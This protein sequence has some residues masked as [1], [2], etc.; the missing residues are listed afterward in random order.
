MRRRGVDRRPIQ[1]E[2]ASRGVSECTTPRAQ[3]NTC[4]IGYL[5]QMAAPSC[6]AHCQ[7]TYTSSRRSSAVITRWDRVCCRSVSLSAPWAQEVPDAVERAALA[8][9][10]AVEVLLDPAADLVHQARE[11]A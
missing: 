11:G 9:A 6:S 1:G 7:A 10:L 4:L 2:R 3:C 5:F 8:P